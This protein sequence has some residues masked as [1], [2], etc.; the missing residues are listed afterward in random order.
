MHMVLSSIE[1]FETALK[2]NPEKAEIV[3]KIKESYFDGAKYKENV[4]GFDIYTAV[5]GN[6]VKSVEEFATFVSTNGLSE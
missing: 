3:L 1:R 4:K 2:E 5:L 6:D